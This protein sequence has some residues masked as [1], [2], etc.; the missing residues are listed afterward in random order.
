MI[1]SCWFSV[2]IG[3]IW[4]KNT[5]YF[6]EKGGIYFGKLYLFF[7]NFDPPFSER[8]TVHTR[9]S[10]RTMYTI[11]YVCGFFCKV[12]LFSK[13]GWMFP[14]FFYGD[15]KT[16]QNHPVWIYHVYKNLHMYTR[17][18]HP[19]LTRKYRNSITVYI[20]RTHYYI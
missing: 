7:E 12:I 15:L 18:V 3:K 10:K 17:I 8:L 9:Y 2:K 16:T 6:L 4:Q 5:T 13:M 19:V 14:C 11:N 1:R 20:Q